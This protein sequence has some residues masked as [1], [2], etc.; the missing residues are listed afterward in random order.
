[1]SKVI[2]NNLL[3]NN[4]KIKKENNEIL[5]IFYDG[6][7]DK[8]IKCKYTLLLTQKNITSDTSLIVWAD[9][10]PYNDLITREIAT[11][12]RDIFLSKKNYILDCNNQL[13]FNKDLSNIINNIIKNNYEISIKNKIINTLWV[14]S[15]NLLDYIEYYIITDIIYY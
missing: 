3:K 13:I 1:M 5:Y 2:F 10:N 9:A 14:I 4:Y 7:I 8:K 15:N 6:N 12:I 11:K